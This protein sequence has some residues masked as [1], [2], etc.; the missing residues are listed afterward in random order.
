MRQ[1]E[2]VDGVRSNDK[3]VAAVHE[4]NAVEECNEV[5]QEIGWCSSNGAVILERVGRGRPPMGLH[6]S[7]SA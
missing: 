7:M 3:G 2:D 5:E 6:A 1:D 4:L